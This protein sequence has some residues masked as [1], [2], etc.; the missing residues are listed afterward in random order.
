MLKILVIE[1]NIMQCK[2]IVNYISK[3]DENIKLYNMAYTYKEATEIIKEQIA[4]IILLDLNFQDNSGIE[5]LTFIQENNI[6]KYRDSIIVISGEYSMLNNIKNSPFIYSCI[7][8]PYTLS[9]IKNKL[10]AISNYINKEMIMNKIANELKQ[11]HYNFSYNGTKYLAETIFEIYCKGNYLVDN[12]TKDIYPIIAKRHCKS[13]NTICGNIKQAT[14]RMLL[15]C[16]EKIINEYF[17]YSY[18]IH[19]KLKE[20]IFTILNKIH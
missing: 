16:E 4:D 9:H 3:I 6:I 11:L 5:I 20:I 7:Y 13:I 2:Q 17:N 8:K 18:F 14:K 10:I 15:D 19:P 12:L 1:D